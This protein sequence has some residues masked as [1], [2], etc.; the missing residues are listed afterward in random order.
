MFVLLDTTPE[1]ILIL[2]KAKENL[3]ESKNFL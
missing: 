2:D 1:N 3:I